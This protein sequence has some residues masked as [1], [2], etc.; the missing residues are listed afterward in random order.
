MRIAIEQMTEL[1]GRTIQAISEVDDRIVMT[2]TD[3]TYAAIASVAY[4]DYSLSMPILEAISPD[5]RFQSAAEIYRD[6]GVWTEV[7]Y[8]DW[9]V[10]YNSDTEA[11]NRLNELNE[12]RTYEQLKQK[13]EPGNR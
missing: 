8:S 10:R 7:E 11:R 12:R 13:F 3:G 1:V 4:G 6:L 5:V 9:L 2:F